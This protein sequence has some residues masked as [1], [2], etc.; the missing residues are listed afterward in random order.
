MDSSAFNSYLQS[1]GITDKRVLEAFSKVPR[2]E[3]VRPSDIKKA[4][5]DIP[6]PIGEGQTISQPSLVALMTQELKLKGSEKVLEIGTGSGYQTAILS[7]LSKKVYSIE[8]IASLANRAKKVLKK[9]GYKNIK[10][11]IRDG[12]KGLKKYAPYDG[13]MVT[14]GANIIPKS[15]IDQLKERGRIVVPVGKTRT[16]QVL[17]VGIKNKRELKIQDIEPV[18]FVPL[19]G[20]YGWS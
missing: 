20:K 18:K 14:A 6:L 15:L 4:Y 1:I 13:I 11:I 12:T 2:S 9:L 8:R 7:C 10:V 17:Q 16:D 19:I 3:F 5:E